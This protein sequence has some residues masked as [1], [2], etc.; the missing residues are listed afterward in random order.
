MV[1][2]NVCQV[3]WLLLLA[4]V[5]GVLVPGPAWKWGKLTIWSC[6]VLITIIF[7]LLRLLVLH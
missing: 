7:M 3:L 2:I 6:L 1:T 5:I 4:Y